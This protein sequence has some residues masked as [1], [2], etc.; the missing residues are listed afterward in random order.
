MRTCETVFFRHKYLTMPTITPADALI[1][2]SDNLIDAISGLIPKPT[3]TAD[4][5][6]QLMEIYKIQAHRS[7][8]E[9]QAQR[10]L[11][12]K[13]QAQ[14][15]AEKQQAT[16]QQM[17]PQQNPTSF[18]VL[19]IEDS[20]SQGFSNKRRPPIISQDYNES[21][22]HNTCQQHLTQT[23]TQDYMFHMMEIPGY[24]QPFT[25]AQAASRT[26]PLQFI[27]DF[28]FAV[29]NDN[30]G[31]LLE[32]C[33]LMKHPKHKDTWTASFSKEIRRLA[34]TTETISS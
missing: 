20:H 17:I 3:V 6:E 4:A 15:V 32:Y 18:P 13:A 5:I 28:A 11:R 19:E 24:K 16:V 34:T 25:A 14:R 12:E 23:L 26:Y 22:A 2:A 29:L 9:A 33:H 27:C 8:C 10:V 7:T 30:T 1:K 21:P 31:D